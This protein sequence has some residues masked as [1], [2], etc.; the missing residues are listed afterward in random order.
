MNNNT[1]PQRPQQQKRRTRHTTTSDED[2][3]MAT[4]KLHSTQSSSSLR[5]Q[6]RTPQQAN[7]FFSQQRPQQNK[8]HRQH[9]VSCCTPTGKLTPPQLVRL[10]KATAG[11]QAS[12][13]AGSKF[14]DSPAP[15]TIPLPPIHWFSTD[16][17]TPSRARISPTPSSV[18]DLSSASSFEDAKSTTSSEEL[19]SFEPHRGGFRVNPMHLIAAVSAIA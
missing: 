2:L 13:F 19:L 3:L 10:H 12:L 18:S 16:L 9:S 7:Q 1:T 11:S 4:P 8:L 17:S 14:M 15:D 5:Q 6:R